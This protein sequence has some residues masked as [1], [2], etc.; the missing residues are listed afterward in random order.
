MTPNAFNRATPPPTLCASYKMS[1][2]PVK[3]S[4][5]PVVTL[6]RRAQPTGEKVNSKRATPTMT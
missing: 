5:E 4:D 3:V 1:E 6:T 2:L